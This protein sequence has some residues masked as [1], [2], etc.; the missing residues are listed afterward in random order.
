MSQPSKCEV[1]LAVPELTPGTYA[2]WRATE[3]G[4]TTERLE[5]QLIRESLGDVQGMSIL[6]IG[7]GDGDLAVELASKGARVAAIDISEEMLTAARERA[8]SRQVSVDFQLGAAQQIP[9]ENERF[10]LVVAMTILCFVPDAQPVFKEIARVLKPGGRLI[11]GE[12]GKWSTWSAERRVRAWLGSK[13]WQRGVFR[14]PSEL[15]RLAR[16]AGLEPLGVRGSVYYPRLTLAARVLAPHD[17]AISGV[18]ALGAA[19]LRLEARKP[20]GHTT[21]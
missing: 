16:S 14:T 13:L 11:I 20:L 19:F 4:T 15:K 3:L 18:T 12:L 6:E 2:R 8:Q 1:P 10:D 5:R 7:C 9:H 17:R 21:P